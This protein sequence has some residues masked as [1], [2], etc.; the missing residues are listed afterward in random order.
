MHMVFIRHDT[1]IEFVSSEFKGTQIIKNN[2]EETIEQIKDMYLPTSWEV[3]D[4]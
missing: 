3:I 4:G 1:R 2:W